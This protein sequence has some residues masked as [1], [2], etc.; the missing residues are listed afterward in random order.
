M[1]SLIG[2]HYGSRGKEVKTKLNLLVS[3]SHLNISNL[4]LPSLS[5]GPCLSKANH[6]Y[7]SHEAFV[8]QSKYPKCF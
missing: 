7:L 8:P 1:P 6:N 5:L 4:C 2:G 3:D